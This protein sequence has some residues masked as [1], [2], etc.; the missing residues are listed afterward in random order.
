MVE[1]QR[2]EELRGF[3]VLKEPMR[4]QRD[5]SSAEEYYRANPGA[6]RIT[7]ESTGHGR[8]WTIQIK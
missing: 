3:S 5:L 2:I 7:S 1:I 6:R 8:I 4:F